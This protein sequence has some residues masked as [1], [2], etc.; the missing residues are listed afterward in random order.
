[1]ATVFP[2]FTRI[3]AD[4]DIL[5]G[6]PCVRGMRLSVQQVLHILAQFDDWSEIHND[7]PELEPEDVPE[8][9]RFAAEA[10]DDRF[11]FEL[12]AG[13]SSAA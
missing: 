6:K 1:M 8:I 4:P 2:G 13:S 7:Y 9:L 10:L 12:P 11:I 3:T 5:G